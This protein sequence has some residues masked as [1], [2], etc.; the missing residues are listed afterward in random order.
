MKSLFTADEITNILTYKNT[1]ANVF[2]KNR[3]HEVNI[4]NKMPIILPID[5]SMSEKSIARLVFKLKEIQSEV[6]KEFT[7]TR[8]INECR[9]HQTLYEIFDPFH[10]I[11]PVIHTINNKIGYTFNHAIY[12]SFGILS[13][14]GLKDLYEPV[15]GKYNLLDIIHIKKHTTLPYHIHKSVNNFSLD[16]VECMILLSGDMKFY[17]STHPRINI[18]EKYEGI[19]PKYR[20][21][22]FNPEILHT[23]IALTEDVYLLYL[24]FNCTSFTELLKHKDK[25]KY[26]I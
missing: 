18:V 8:I 14:I 23:G 15:N 7:S 24:R 21:I 17:A 9:D 22:A 2:F 19:L 1:N 12:D 16:G 10:T 5:L 11:Y 25:D 20:I 4:I 26:S 6:D 13:E 3:S